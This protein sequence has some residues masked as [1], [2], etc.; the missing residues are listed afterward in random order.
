MNRQVYPAECIQY[1]RTLKNRSLGAVLLKL[2]HVNGGENVVLNLYFYP[3]GIG[4]Y[5]LFRCFD[6]GN[7]AIINTQAVPNFLNAVVEVWL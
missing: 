4:I 2:R 5:P 3:S 1:S 6:M 7:V